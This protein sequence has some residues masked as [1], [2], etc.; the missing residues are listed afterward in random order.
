MM[1]HGSNMLL[2]TFRPYLN[3]EGKSSTEHVHFL[4]VYL[5]AERLH[6]YTKLDQFV[7][8]FLFHQIIAN[9]P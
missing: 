4:Y 6:D 2:F 8:E 7:L 3:M 1:F 9:L 5:P